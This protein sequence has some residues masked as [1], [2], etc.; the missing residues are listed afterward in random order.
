M[1]ISFQRLNPFVTETPQIAT[2][3]KRLVPLAIAL[4]ARPESYI[5]KITCGEAIRNPEGNLLGFLTISVRNRKYHISN[6]QYDH[7]GA[8][9]PPSAEPRMIPK[10]QYMLIDPTNQFDVTLRLKQ[11]E[12]Q[13]LAGWY[14]A[15]ISSE[16]KITG[17]NPTSADL[18]LAIANQQFKSPGWDN[19]ESVM[20]TKDF[21]ARAIPQLTD[22]VPST[23]NIV[24]MTLCSK[25][26]NTPG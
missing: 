11:V 13:A 8:I 26:L 25:V 7:R 12:T 19:P 10:M 24:E 16:V 4:A 18:D 6:T 21:L 23:S 1:S 14:D 3:L 17:D 15:I 5:Y 20:I 22:F 2:Q 9:L